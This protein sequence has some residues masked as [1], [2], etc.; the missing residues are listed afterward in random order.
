MDV[1]RL[2]GSSSL[3]TTLKSSSRSSACSFLSRA[4]VRVQR[5]RQNLPTMMVFGDLV[6]SIQ[7][8]T[9]GVLWYSMNNTSLGEGKAALFK[10]QVGEYDVEK[11]KEKLD[12]Y[13]NENKVIHN[14]EAHFLFAGMSSLD[15][16]NATS[17]DERQHLP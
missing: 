10:A 5:V 16:L 3:Q 15:S 13:I 7:V 1:A 2:S 17:G 4:P 11:T 14:Y 9:N 8:A 12:K 6:K